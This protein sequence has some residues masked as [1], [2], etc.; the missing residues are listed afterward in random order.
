VGLW[1]GVLIEW[2][3]GLF[4]ANHLLENHL[5][6]LIYNV[7]CGLNEAGMEAKIVKDHFKLFIETTEIEKTL[8]VI[9]RVFGVARAI[10]CMNVK[11]SK[12][13]DAI[14]SVSEE[15]MKQGLFPI[16]KFTDS[17]S[18]SV[19]EAAQVFNLKNLSRSRGEFTKTIDVNVEVV[20]DSCYVYTSHLAVAGP[21]GLPIGAMG[22]V[23][24]LVSGGIDSPVAAWMM[25]KRGCPITILFAYF[26][27]GGDESDLKRF[28]NVVKRLHKWHVGREMQVYVYRHDQNLVAFRKVALKFTCILCRRMMY[29]VANALA[30]IVGAKAIVTGENLAQVASQTLQNLNVIDQ[31]SELPVLRPLIGFDKE[32]IIEIAKRIGT[33]EASCMKVSSGCASI[34]GCWA[35]PPKPA[36][37]APLN[38]IIEAE[39]NLNIKELLERSVSS[40]K[41]I[42][43]EL[44]IKSF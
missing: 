4:T 21:D 20:E 36:T 26:P 9:Q 24:C 15:F 37:H 28:I 18:L 41:R 6:E 8:S 44:F 2:G 34:R 33:Y 25:M 42:P 39:S 7:E 27:M 38:T 13:H 12:I 14:L 16:I 43:N 10:P 40:L 1:N 35:R 11:L 22:R 23:V 29:R 5:S 17:K 32:E 3:G 30:S 19:K 31:A